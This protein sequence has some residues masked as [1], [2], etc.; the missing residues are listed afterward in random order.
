MV[1]QAESIR[2]LLGNFNARRKVST[3]SPSYY[4]SIPAELPTLK[5][6]LEFKGHGGKDKSTT[7]ALNSETRCEP[8]L[9]KSLP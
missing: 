9:Q 5:L 6:T 4:L 8:S 2:E 3:A 1:N 7:V